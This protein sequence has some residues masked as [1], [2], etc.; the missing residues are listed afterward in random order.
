MNVELFGRRHEG[1]HLLGAMSVAGLEFSRVG[2]LW[3]EAEGVLSLQLLHVSNRQFE[4]ISF[5]QLRNGFS[6]GLQSR[7]HQI[8]ELVQ[9]LVDSGSSLS[10]EQGLHHLSILMGS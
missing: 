10:F 3:S 1:G 7:H 9:T 2:R 5:L 6:F 4:N 8:F